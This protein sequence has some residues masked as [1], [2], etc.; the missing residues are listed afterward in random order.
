MSTH[1]QK[2]NGKLNRRSFLAGSAAA[3]AG[4]ALAVTGLEKAA[5]AEAGGINA[6]IIGTGT[7]GMVLL[8]NS[9]K[10]PGVNFKAVCDIWEYK[11][12]YAYGTVRAATRGKAKPEMYENYEDLLGDKDKLGL[13]AVIV[14]TP[15]FWHAKIACAAMKAGLHVYCEKE[16]DKTL[17]MSLQIAKTAKETGRC[18]QIG[19]QR[20]SNP[21]Y[22]MAKDMVD[23]GDIGKLL[24]CHG[25]WNRW[26]TPMAEFPEGDRFKLSDETLK[27]YGF[28][29]KRHFMNWRWF[30]K[31]SS[32]PIADLGSHQIDIFDWYLDSHPT[33][34][35]AVA[36]SPSKHAKQRE[37][38]ENVFVTYEYEHC[39]NGKALATYRV[40]NTNGYGIYFERFM[41]TGGTI[42]ISEFPEMSYYVPA[43]GQE[44]PKWAEKA[45][46]EE[47][48]AF[49]AAADKFKKGD[50]VGSLI[51]KCP[52]LS[53][54]SQ[55]TPL[56]GGLSGEELTAWKEK[57]IHTHHLENFFDAA[58]AD[59]PKKLNCPPEIAYPTAVAVLNAIPA[60]EAGKKLPLT[61]AA[62]K[63]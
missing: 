52:I 43:K 22:L 23:N 53:Q 37:W 55:A 20:R 49:A 1:A 30:K 7:Q 60:V 16:M 21:V 25:H 51:E 29:S 27:K 46:E 62:Y 3:G 9:L 12:K 36:S 34:L 6:A 50:N 24:S 15:D 47:A 26:V 35:S 38:Y 31:Y 2:S 48:A 54:G 45:Q 42:T 13:Q 40:Q 63:I 19:H 18:C 44:S 28:D 41:G 59:D 61:E 58:R 57:K 39:K 4:A 17:E 8:R 14:A 56:L 33:A 32:G 5:A 11:R 10:I